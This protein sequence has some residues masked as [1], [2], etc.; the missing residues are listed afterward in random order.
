M[1]LKER[2][3]ADLIEVL[4]LGDLFNPCCID[5]VARSHHG[6]EM[7]EPEKFKKAD[8][9]FPSGEGLPRCWTDPD[10][11]EDEIRRQK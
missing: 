6:E 4:S 11:H 2:S 7:Q 9:V 1:F 5:L 8:L 3:S 10:Y